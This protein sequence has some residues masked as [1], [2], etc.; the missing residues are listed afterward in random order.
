MSTL[1]FQQRSQQDSRQPVSQRRSTGGKILEDNRANFTAQLAKEDE[2]PL[3]AKFTDTR[4]PLQRA[5]P[6]SKPNKTGLPDN[7]KN[8]IESLSGMP[9]DNVRVH[10]N[11]SQ[12]AQLN[13]LAYAQGTDIHVAPGQEKH[14]PHEA[15]HV[16][17]QAQGRV[18]PTMQMKEGVAVNDDKGLE[19]E[20]DLMGGRAV[21]LYKY[22]YLGSQM[23]VSTVQLVMQ[24]KA[25]GFG[26]GFATDSAVQ[27]ASSVKYDTT[28]FDLELADGE[29]ELVGKEMT[30][31]LE[32]G[33]PMRGS[34]PGDGVQSLLMGTLKA[35][36][37]MRMIRGHLLNGQLGGLGIAANLFP[38]T[39]SANSKHKN[40]VENPIKQQIKNGKD[41]DYTVTVNSQYK[42][43]DPNAQFICD[44]KATD[45]SWSLKETIESSPGKT[46][47]SDSAAEGKALNNTDTA[48]FSSN[49]IP[50]GWG[51]LG[52][53]YSSS[54]AHKNTAGKYTVNFNGEAHVLDDYL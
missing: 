49:N 9:M 40:H 2:E 11:S 37:Y 47:K 52:K 15:W 48:S 29:K 21:Q 38:I 12:P 45:D 6:P 13:A 32:Q 26:N 51:E 35:N 24:M 7:L 34:A 53:G 43:S 10:Y 19:A 36:G 5:E 39:S 27:L 3:Q 20:A 1:I 4:A 50:K 28:A 16:V 14:L 31:H 42:M 44:A 46:Q 18:Q 33:D 23:P 54:E 30:A 17:Q 41:I 8:G 25:T 22:N